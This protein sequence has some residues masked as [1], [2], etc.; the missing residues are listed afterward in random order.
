MMFL[1]YQN[2]G[3]TCTLFEAHTDEYIWL[4]EKCADGWKDLQTVQT[5]DAALTYWNFEK[6]QRLTNKF[7]RYYMI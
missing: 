7:L 6:M 1:N 4:P 2:F 5:V 3:V